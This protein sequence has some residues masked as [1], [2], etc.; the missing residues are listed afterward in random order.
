MSH[1]LETDNNSTVTT[2]LDKKHSLQFVASITYYKTLSIIGSYPVSGNLADIV[3][4]IKLKS[5][6]ELKSVLL[7]LSQR[8]G[9]FSY[10]SNHKLDGA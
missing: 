3:G 2:D 6:F 9:I 4:E 5:T 10:I 8:T 7:H 1:S